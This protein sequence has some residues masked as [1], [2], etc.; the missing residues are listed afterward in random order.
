[1]MRLAY[2]IRTVLLDYII[3][4]AWLTKYLKNNASATYQVPTMRKKFYRN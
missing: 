4:S 3:R 1:M 2:H